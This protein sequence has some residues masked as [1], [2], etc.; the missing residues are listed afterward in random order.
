MVGYVPKI[1][2]RTLRKQQRIFGTASPCQD[3][4]ISCPLGLACNH[5]GRIGS[6]LRTNKT[7]TIEHMLDG[8]FLVFAPF[9]IFGYTYYI[10]F[11]NFGKFSRENA[12]QNYFNKKDSYKRWCL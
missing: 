6:M 4:S 7:T 8:F 10:I 1:Q 3:L 2:I 9:I 11:F 5:G 12:A